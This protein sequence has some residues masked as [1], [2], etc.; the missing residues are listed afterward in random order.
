ARQGDRI[1]N[2]SV[3]AVG[4]RSGRPRESKE[5]RG[6]GEAGRTTEDTEK[7]GILG[8]AVAAL[9]GN[10]VHDTAL[11]SPLPLREGMGE[12]GVCG[13]PGAPPGGRSGGPFPLP[14]PPRGGG[15][16]GG[17]GSRPLGPVPVW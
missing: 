14:P 4:V 2:A 7:E 13:G 12:G 6:H 16:G 9:L 10:T 5:G 1:W 15:G 8:F 17:G 11:S 3:P